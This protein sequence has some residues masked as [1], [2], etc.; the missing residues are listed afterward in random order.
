MHALRL[1]EA[2]Q[3]SPGDDYRKKN[4]QLDANHVEMAW[5]GRVTAN[6]KYTCI[7]LRCTPSYTHTHL[8]L[9]EMSHAGMLEALL[10]PL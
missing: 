1:S 8:T 10:M 5:S 7:V 2:R 9:L 6:N 3:S 4:K